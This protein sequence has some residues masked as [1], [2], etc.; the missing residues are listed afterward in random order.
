MSTPSFSFSNDDNRNRTIVDEIIL[1]AKEHDTIIGLF[2][3]NLHV[4]SALKENMLQ[5]RFALGPVLHEDGTGDDMPDM[6]L[7]TLHIPIKTPITSKDIITPLKK[8]LRDYL[9]DDRH[10]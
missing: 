9:Y 7:T 6:A 2:A 4:S 3:D 8:E 10:V 5:I 1:H